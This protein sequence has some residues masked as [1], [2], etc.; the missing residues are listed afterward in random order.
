MRMYLVRLALH[1]IASGIPD[2]TSVW[3]ISVPGSV[4][5]LGRLK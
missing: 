3:Q 5:H 2:K 1:V 4:S